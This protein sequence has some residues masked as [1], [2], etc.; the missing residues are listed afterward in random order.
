[1]SGYTM[2]GTKKRGLSPAAKKKAMG[3][4]KDAILAGNK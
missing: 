3:K 2:E 4:A 1:M